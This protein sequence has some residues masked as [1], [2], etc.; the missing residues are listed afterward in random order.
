MVSVK[1]KI[2]LAVLVLSGIVVSQ[3]CFAA[4]K[5]KAVKEQ[6]KAASVKVEVKAEP[7]VAKSKI[8]VVFYSRTGNTKKVA[9]EI[10]A[11]LKCDIEE[12]LDTKDRSGMSGYMASGKEAMK[13][14][15]AVIKEIKNNP[16]NYDLV[17][18]GTPVWAGKMS[19]PVR[20]YVIQNKEKLKNV[21]FFCTMGG[22]GNKKAFADMEEAIGKKPAATMTILER[23]VKKNEYKAKVEGFVKELSVK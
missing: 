19:S 8:L 3:H 17:I 1:V 21:A 20:T 11:E 9:E 23:E 22:G 5:K 4:A 18:L 15:V 10:A 2:A 6:P 7:S 12:I 16:A 13:K 14:Q